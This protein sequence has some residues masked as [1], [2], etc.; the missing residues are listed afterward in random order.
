MQVRK[1]YMRNP[2]KAGET[3]LL[4]YSYREITILLFCHRQN[5]RRITTTLIITNNFFILFSIWLIIHFLCIRTIGDFFHLRTW[6]SPVLLTYLAAQGKTGHLLP[7]TWDTLKLSEPG[8]VLI[9][10]HKFLLLL[11][12]NLPT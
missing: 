9:S 5:N 11:Q 4:V 2:F 3:L 1:M 10:L 12:R 8:M 6:P 7:T